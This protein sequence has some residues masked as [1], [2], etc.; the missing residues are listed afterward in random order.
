LAI[1]PLNRFALCPVSLA[2]ALHFRLS[3]DSGWRLL[4]SS[5]RLPG[6]WSNFVDSGLRVQSLNISP[7]WFSPHALK[8]CFIPVFGVN[9]SNSEAIT[10]PLFASARDALFFSLSRSSVHLRLHDDFAISSAP[11]LSQAPIFRPI[12][13]PLA[14]SF[15]EAG[16]STR[17]FKGF[18]D[19]CFCSKAR[20]FSAIETQFF[21]ISL[22]LFFSDEISLPR[23]LNVVEGLL[24]FSHQVS[25]RSIAEVVL[26][27]AP[28]SGRPCCH[29]LLPC[30]FPIV[31]AFS[32]SRP[33]SPES[34]SR[35]VFFL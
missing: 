18:S 26:A 2:G 32:W 34:F 24:P 33:C 10:R 29:V 27:P 17:C 22:S 1:R 20:R 3:L 21:P 30:M 31:S 12:S 9:C 23:L 14:S 8:F 4:F 13:S 7:Y 25:L 5:L 16:P 28:H 6:L 11:F 35:Y 19:P 15:L